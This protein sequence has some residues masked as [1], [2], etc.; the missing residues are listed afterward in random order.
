MEAEFDI[1]KHAYLG[2]SIILCLLILRTWTLVREFSICNS[3][4]L[5]VSERGYLNLKTIINGE[6][7]NLNLTLVYS[8][9]PGNL[10][11]LTPYHHHLLLS[12]TEGGI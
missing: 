6:G 8:A 12:L 1:P 9:F 7:M 10:P 4:S 5:T 3:V 2:I 11:Q